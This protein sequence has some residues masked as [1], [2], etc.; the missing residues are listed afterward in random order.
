MHNKKTICQDGF[1]VVYA[2]N[3][4]KPRTKVLKTGHRPGRKR[5]D[6]KTAIQAPAPV[7]PPQAGAVDIEKFSKNIARMVEE[8]GKALAAYLKPREEGEVKIEPADEIADVVKTLGQVA[9]YWLSDPQRT[10]EVQMSLGKAYL[11]LWASAMQRMAGEP[12]PPMV[13]PDPKDKRFADPEW[14]SNQ[15]YDFLKQAYLLTTQWA[16]RLVKN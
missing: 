8:G 14:S 12:A 7:A 3:M 6:E 10:V 5:M 15:F 9:E 13:Q 4:T 11:D 16:D 2:A 1:K